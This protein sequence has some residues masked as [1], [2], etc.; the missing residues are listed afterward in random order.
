VIAR[1]VLSWFPIRPYHP[2]IQFLTWATEPLL[3]PIRNFFQTRLHYFGPIDWSPF[4]LLLGLYLV[5]YLLVQGLLQL[6]AIL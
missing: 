3:R 1:A 2:V 5:R 4:I 6:A